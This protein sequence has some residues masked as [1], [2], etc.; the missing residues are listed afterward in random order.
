MTDTSA[1]GKQYLLASG[2]NDIALH[3]WVVEIG[4]QILGG[5]TTPTI[6]PHHTLRGHSGPIMCVRFSADGLILA[7]ASGDK[8]VMLWDPV[9]YT[10]L[11][12][13]VEN[14]TVIHCKVWNVE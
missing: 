14:T 3:L 13:F 6:T 12:I 4:S 1:L 10:V 11:E 9:R 5:D 2:G 7:S 8:T